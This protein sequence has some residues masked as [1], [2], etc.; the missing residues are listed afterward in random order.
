MRSKAL[1]ISILLG[2]LAFSTLFAQENLSEE[3][4]L[5]KIAEYEQCIAEK[6]PI[7][8]ALRAEVAALQAEVDQLL[9]RKSELNRQIAELTRAPEYT[10]YIV[11]EGDCLWWI[12]KREYQ[13]RGQRWYLWKMIY[14]DNRDV[15]GAN[16][17][18]I[19]PKQQFRLNQDQNVWERYRQ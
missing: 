12:A 1:L 3:E 18:L 10:T 15:I 8:E 5:A 13:P 2:L 19:L 11:K 7:V 14:D 9:A 6:T 16:P 17:D 4:A